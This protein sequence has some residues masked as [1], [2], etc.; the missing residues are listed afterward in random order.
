M[1][2]TTPNWSIIAIL[3]HKY[4]DQGAHTPHFSK[5]IR[6]SAPLQLKKLLAFVYQGALL[7]TFAATF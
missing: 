1:I 2:S 3:Q 5:I 4:N 6:Q 7:N